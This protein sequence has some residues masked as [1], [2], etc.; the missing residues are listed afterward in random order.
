MASEST[1]EATLTVSL[2]AELDNWLDDRAA[3]LDVDRETVLVQ[4]LASYRAAAELDG[5]SNDG[6]TALA[7]TE[8]VEQAVESKVED[9]V[10]QLDDRIADATAGIQQQL[11]QR[12]DA[13]EDDYN[14][15]LAD[16]RERVVQLKRELDGKAPADHSHEDFQRIE[17]LQAAIDDLRADLEGE[18][19]DRETAVG[20]LSET[21]ETA[22]ED[23]A[24]LRERLQTVAWVVSDL[25]E[26][27]E[28]QTGMDAVDRIKRAAA[29][30]DV[31]RAK[32]ENCG[33][34]VDIAL[35]TD[36]E[37]PHCQATVTDVQAANGFFGKPRLLVA[38]QLESGDR[39]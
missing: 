14:E 16:V 27:H 35:M 17:E 4:L 13:L 22:E 18:I 31:D 36:P 6:V 29:R 15:N 9:V 8:T 1:E 12:L 39:S 3:S 37:C 28:Q 33:E 2:P 10:G 5:E 38:S 26:A 24:E 23:I 20:D 19:A 25:R 32:C 11:G 30:M 34:G 21:V 7:G